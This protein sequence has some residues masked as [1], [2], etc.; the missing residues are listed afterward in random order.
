MTEL[1]EHDVPHAKRAPGTT[2]GER[3]QGWSWAALV[4]GVLMIVTAGLTH[5]MA[6]LYVSLAPSYMSDTDTRLGLTISIVDVLTMIVLGV[7]GVLSGAFGVRE[8]SRRGGGGGFAVMT[9][10]V[11]SAGMLIWSGAA[12]NLLIVAIS[13]LR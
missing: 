3:P 4:L 8:A 11:A 6:W 1:F 13:R 12:A 7:L 10:V 9:L 2:G 5:I